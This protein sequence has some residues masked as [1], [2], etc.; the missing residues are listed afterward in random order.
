MCGGDIVRVETHQFQGDCRLL[1]FIKLIFQQPILS[2]Y[3]M[4]LSI[5]NTPGNLR[6]TPQPSHKSFIFLYLALSIPSWIDMARDCER[7]RRKHGGPFFRCRKTLILSYWERM[8]RSRSPRTLSSPLP[9]SGS[10]MSDVW[11]EGRF[12]PA[13]GPLN[14]W[15]S[16]GFTT[17]P[18]PELETSRSPREWSA[19]TR[20]KGAQTQTVG[21]CFDG[22]V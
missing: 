18:T 22:W 15:P 7:G 1:I 20:Q 17:P 4:Q 8:Q 2:R 5:P 13:K 11:A 19:Q 10:V 14:A 6:R 3:Y 16:W 21:F 9:N 12:Y